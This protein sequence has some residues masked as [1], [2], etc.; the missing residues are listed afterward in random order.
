VRVNE[1]KGG[2]TRNARKQAQKKR[3]VCS[4]F[5]TIRG[6][7]L[8]SRRPVVIIENV[9]SLKFSRKIVEIVVEGKIAGKS[10]IPVQKRKRAG[11]VIT[12]PAHFACN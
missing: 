5:S 6:L 8:T 11:L 1:F 9:E 2:N 4:L 12:N 7:P 3:A 10:A